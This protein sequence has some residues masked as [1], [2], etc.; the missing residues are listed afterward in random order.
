MD[1][2]P[3]EYFYCV[4]DKRHNLLVKIIYLLY[5]INGSYTGMMSKLSPYFK[6][7]WNENWKP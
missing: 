3:K 2:K 4:R 1:L 5:F 6:L 7:E